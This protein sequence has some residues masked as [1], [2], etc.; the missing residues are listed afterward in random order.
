[1]NFMTVCS[2]NIKFH[3]DHLNLVLHI[4]VFNHD[5]LSQS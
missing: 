1:M 3:L 2:N 4:F 5:N